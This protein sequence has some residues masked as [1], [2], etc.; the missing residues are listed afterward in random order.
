MV[1]STTALSEAAISARKSSLETFLAD[2]TKGLQAK[3]SFVEHS[4]AD[5]EA[6][7]GPWNEAVKQLKAMYA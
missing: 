4:L 7:T 3:K 2:H 6:Q 5:L 1:A